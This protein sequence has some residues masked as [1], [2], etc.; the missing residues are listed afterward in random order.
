MWCKIFKV[1]F[2]HRRLPILSQK[3]LHPL[4]M[5]LLVNKLDLLKQ[6][7]DNSNDT[8]AALLQQDYLG[9]TPLH[10]L[11]VRGGATILICTSSWSHNVLTPWS[12]RMNGEVPLSN[13]YY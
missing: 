4:E 10:V 7:L 9:M 2:R 11:P 3:V 1:L 5:L 8:S 13:T 12:L 6:L